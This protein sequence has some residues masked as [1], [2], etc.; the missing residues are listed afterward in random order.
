VQT[1][2]SGLCPADTDVVADQTPFNPGRDRIQSFRTAPSDSQYVSSNGNGH[3]SH[4]R[5]E[6]RA[7]PPFGERY[8]EHFDPHH[9]STGQLV[10]QAAAQVSA[11]VRTEIALGKA[12]I[13]EKGKRLGMGAGLLATA[14]LLGLYAF[15]LLIALVAMILDRDWPAWLAVLVPLLALGT[16][17]LLLAAFGISRLRSGA[18]APTETPNSLRD[19]FESV[20]HAFQE[21]RNSR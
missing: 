16:L 1:P 13:M 15:G 11:L 10:T 17:C 8:G 3:G 19:D 7:A 20:K 21:G 5:G 9:A 12:E 4:G 18:E 14:G 6:L 2:D